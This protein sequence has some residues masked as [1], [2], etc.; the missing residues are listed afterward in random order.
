[1]NATF[2]S[3]QQ[4]FNDLIGETSSATATTAGQRHINATVNDIIGQY[5]FSWNTKTS[6]LTLVA[7]VAT[8]PT[9]FYAGWGI[10]DARIVNSSTGDDE[11]FA[12][13]PTV[14]R[15]SYD[16]DTPIYWITYDTTTFEYIFHSN[17]QTGTVE[18]IYHFIPA[19]MSAVGDHCIIPDGEL[20]A[21]GAAAKNWVADERNIELK[22]EYEA[23]Y[24]NGVKALY[25][26]DLQN[27]AE[28][29][30]DSLASIQTWNY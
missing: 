4:R 2:G 13:V 7:G 25:L 20:V 15:D 29:M 26:Q 10:D 9:D 23:T 30:V 6:S 18:I 24:N 17:R 1:M 16:S 19:D 21:Y 12:Y 22:R 3:I 28:Y 11:I 27:G 14:D 5:S 8:L